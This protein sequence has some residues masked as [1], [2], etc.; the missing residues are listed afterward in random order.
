MIRVR[1]VVLACALAGVVATACSFILDV[2][3]LPP[4][5]EDDAALGDAE[6]GD[7]DVGFDGAIE[8]D[9]S[10]PE[11]DAEADVDADL[12]ADARDGAD[13]GDGDANP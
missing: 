2:E 5:A 6:A 9:G 7:S 3:P 13:A 12:D 11:L 1:A 4:F 8:E 10:A